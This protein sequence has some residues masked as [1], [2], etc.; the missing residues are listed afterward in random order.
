MAEPEPALEPDS[1]PGRWL[2][3]LGSIR[4]S[5]T[6]EEVAQVF[7]TPLLELV[8][9]A[10][11]VHRMYND[12]QMVQRCTLLSIKTGG[13]PETCTYCAQ[14]SSWS[15]EVGLKAEKLMGMEEVLE[16]AR[17]AKAAGSTRFCMG[18]AWR[19]P[20]QIRAMD[21]EVCTTLG[22]L[23]PD[24][25]GDLRE[26]G[27]TAYNHNLDTSPEYYSKITSSRKYEDRLATLEAVREAGISVCAGGI[28][29]LGEGPTDRVGLL[30]Q[31]ATLR[32]H[33][34]SVPI[35][36]LVAVAGTP[37][38]GAAP[39]G[40]LEVVRCV[41][42]ARVLMPRSVVRLSA[43]RLKFSKTDQAMCFLAGANSI[44]D[45]DKLLTT[46]NNERDEDAAMFAE[47]GLTSRPAFLPYPAGAAS[48][49]GSDAAQDSCAAPRAAALGMA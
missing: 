33:P 24:Q 22:M 32:E 2:R 36:A 20:S 28:I 48:S 30:H 44:F 4:S 41:A 14:S 15:K 6:R 31:L 10:A 16:A 26:A 7:N 47:L 27:L 43:G 23:T 8:F 34:E 25:A 46:A 38:E 17:R 42:A 19:G 21:M 35:N 1:D 40:P 3:E 18:A 37:L 49:N 9:H 45:G 29:G 13:C 11:T 5:W 12:P 39:P